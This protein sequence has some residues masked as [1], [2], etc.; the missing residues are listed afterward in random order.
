MARLIPTSLGCYRS[1]AVVNAAGFNAV[2]KEVIRLVLKTRSH[3]ECGWIF[4]C[5]KPP[6][7]HFTPRPIFECGFS[8]GRQVYVYNVS[9]FA[10]VENVVALRTGYS[11]YLTY[12]MR[13]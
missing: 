6:A 3:R 4:P 7:R 9:V 8:L 12:L 10:L 1:N 13:S 11:K 2:V 5:G